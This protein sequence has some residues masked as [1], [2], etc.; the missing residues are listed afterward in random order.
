MEKSGLLMPLAE[1]H[2]RFK[3][4]A[5]YEDEIIVETAIEKMTYAKVVFAY[6]VYRKADHPAFSRRRHDSRVYG[7]VS[8]TNKC[9]QKLSGA[10]Y[11]LDRIKGYK[12][13]FGRGRQ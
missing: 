3:A 12:V 10:L 13:A 7:Q 11:G 5:R 4:P 8:K 2:C 9:G 6:K 1:M